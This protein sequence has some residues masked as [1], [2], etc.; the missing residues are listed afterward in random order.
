MRHNRRFW[1]LFRMNARFTGCVVRRNESCPFPDSDDVPSGG[2]K[3][4]TIMS[5]AGGI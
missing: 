4:S 5:A 2:A 1:R 3:S